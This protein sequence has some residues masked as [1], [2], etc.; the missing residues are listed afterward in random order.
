MTREGIVPALESAHAFAGAFRELGQC[1]RDES[2]IITMSGRG[3]KDIF[4]I[5]EGLQDEEWKTFIQRKNARYQQTDS[6]DSREA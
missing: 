1:S 5:A 6:G 2:V 4:T 3:D